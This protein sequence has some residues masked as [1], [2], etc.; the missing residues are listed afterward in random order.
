MMDEED[1]LQSLLNKPRCSV[2]GCNRDGIDK[3]GKVS[4][5]TPQDG[6]INMWVC[7][8]HWDAILRPLGTQGESE[9]TD[10]LRRA[11]A[12]ITK[13]TLGRSGP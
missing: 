13:A 7:T 9:Q 3:R 5:R 8:T 11:K 6:R 12:A 2:A 10:R 1:E 4:F